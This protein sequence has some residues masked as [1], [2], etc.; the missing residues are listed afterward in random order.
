MKQNILKI[1]SAIVAG[2]FIT[3]MAGAQKSEFHWEQLNRKSNRLEG[4]LTGTVF[5]L[6]SKSNS[7]YFLQ[8]EWVQGSITLD[9]NDF[10][11]GI[12]MRYNAFEDKLVVYNDNLRSLFT[13]DKERVRSFTVNTLDGEHKF[14]RYFY[15]G[16]P[17]GE[18]YFEVLYSGNRDFLAFREIV[19]EKTRPYVDKFGIM[20]DIRFKENSTYFL[21][22]PETGFKKIRLRR[23]SVL[24]VFPENK[25][26]IRRL[27]RRNK[28]NNFEEK[29]M[30]RAIELL[31]K[32]GNFQ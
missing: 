17:A 28:V 32:N 13:V 5:V 6:S 9:D 2:V 11:D 25:R 22:S 3:S 10:Y 27:L 24:N 19:E 16:Y 15:N 31:D 1:W 29:G 4:K 18:R 12:K 26:E 7:N 23:R 30:I 8:N 20:K 14:V 21:Y